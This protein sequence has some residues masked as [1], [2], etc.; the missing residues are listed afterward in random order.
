MPTMPKEHGAV[1]ATVF[2]QL[3]FAPNY[4]NRFMQTNKHGAHLWLMLINLNRR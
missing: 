3:G 2:M 1:R 4:M